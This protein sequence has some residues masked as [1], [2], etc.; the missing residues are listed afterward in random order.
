MRL[1]PY[2]NTHPR[3]LRKAALGE[4]P[5]A[6]PPEKQNRGPNDA[7]KES[8]SGKVGK[9]KRTPGQTETETPARSKSK[10][11]AGDSRFVGAT[12]LDEKQK[13]DIEKE[14]KRRRIGDEMGRQIFVAAVEYQI[15]AFA[16]QLVRSDDAPR[17]KPPPR[18]RDRAL[19]QILIAVE[20]QAR[21]LSE[22]LLQVPKPSMPQL[23]RVLAAQDERGRNYDE[24]YLC[25]LGGE[26]DRLR[27]ACSAM[28]SIEEP[29]DTAPDTGPD[30]ETS[31]GFVRKLAGIFAECFEQDPNAAAD[32]PFRACLEVL[33]QMTPYVIGHDPDFLSRILGER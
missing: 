30:P 16:D 18:P 5:A 2:V 25:E 28:T 12:H 19:E 29:M 4:D 1:D 8:P 23:A 6:A 27:R 14:L 21:L 11:Q 31:S 13:L 24:G 3:L 9:G 22:L 7:A 17:A 33:D 32:G 20:E 15:S 26:I 10:G